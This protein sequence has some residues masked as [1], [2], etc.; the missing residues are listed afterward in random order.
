MAP[1]GWILH[2]LPVTGST[3]DDARRLALEGAP[4]RTIVLADE[5]RAGRGRLGRGWIAPRGSGL[6]LSIVFERPIPSVA[7]T[8]P[9]AIAIVDAIHD[10]TGLPPLI[11]WPNDLMIG[12]RK[13]C[14]ILTEVLRRDERT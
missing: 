13:V 4:E 7:L 11:K 6:L 5:Q 9:C 14:G 2:Y 8:A 1:P 3:N 12:A 10:L